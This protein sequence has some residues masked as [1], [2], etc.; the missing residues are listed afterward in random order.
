MSVHRRW[1][2][3]SRHWVLVSP[4]RTQRPWQGQQ[5][6]VV[7]PAEI[8][9]DPSCYLCPGNRR[10][11]GEINPNYDST[12]S[13]DNDFPAMLPHPQPAAVEAEGIL[14]AQPEAGICRVLCYGPHHSRS[15]SQM[16]I[17]HIED[18]IQLWRREFSSIAR[19]PWIRN[20]QIFEN[21]GEM[22]GASNPHPHG[23]LWANET[24]PSQIE[25]EAQSQEEHWK[26]SGRSLLADCL[27]EEE[28]SGERIVC[29]NDW[30]VA[31]VPFWAVWPFETMIVPRRHFGTII[32]QTPKEDTALAAILQEL[33]NRYDN[34]FQA[35]FP[36]SF[37]L[38]A[39]PVNGDYYQGWHFHMHFYPPLLRSATVRKFMVGYELLAQPQR[40]TT[41]EMA[42]I[43]LREANSTE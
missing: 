21:R 12:F 6:S 39:R 22:M 19:T 26:S 43:R 5:E 41:P 33:T 2:P 13:F 38:H 1:N 30:F 17:A 14:R 18:I 11:N 37:G 24:V 4:H 15:M 35:P 20:I 29:A 42:A 8:A 16:T 3:L 9:Y 28:A 27:A 40:D 34:L 25:I 36:Y 31:L 7:K 23:Q 32:E 10:A